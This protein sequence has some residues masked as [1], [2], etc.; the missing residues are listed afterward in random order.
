MAYYVKFIRVLLNNGFNYYELL[1]L[2]FV[3]FISHAFMDKYQ[4]HLFFFIYL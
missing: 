3:K 1:S 4:N 2:A